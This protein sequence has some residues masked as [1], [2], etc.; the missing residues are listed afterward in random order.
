MENSVRQRL[1]QGKTAYLTRIFA[2]WRTVH[3]DSLILSL[4]SV[5]LAWIEFILFDNKFSPY[6]ALYTNL[7]FGRVAEANISLSYAVILE[8][9]ANHVTQWG[10]DT[11]CNFIMSLIII[12]II[13]AFAGFI[14]FAVEKKYR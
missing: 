10:P 2:R 13:A 7:S 8:G 5:S 3:I 14:I 6:C 4:I 12:N 1:Y 11:V 9:D